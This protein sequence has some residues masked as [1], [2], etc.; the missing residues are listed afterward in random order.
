[1]ANYE[2][3]IERIL[4]KDEGL[5]DEQRAKLRAY[6]AWMRRN[7]NAPG[8]R[9]N[10]LVLLRDLGRHLKGQPYE[11][12][13]PEGVLGF[14]DEVLMDYEQ[15]REALEEEGWKVRRIP[16]SRFMEDQGKYV[17]KVKRALKEEE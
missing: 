11:N 8:T 2:G 9:Y 5:S 14:V 1:M 17:E 13:S 16:Y 15:E 12:R 4:T 3:W 6:N 7:G 10:A